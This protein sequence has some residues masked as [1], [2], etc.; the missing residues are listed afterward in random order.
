MYV[1]ETYQTVLLYTQFLLLDNRKVKGK[2]KGGKGW[3]VANGASITGSTIE[4]YIFP[5][6][7][8][9]SGLFVLRARF[10]RETARRTERKKKKENEENG[11]RS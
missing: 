6:I 3:K 4:D 1:L 11:A 8:S 5:I 2:K 7:I 10:G 9:L